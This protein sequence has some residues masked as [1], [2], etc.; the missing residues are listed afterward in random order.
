MDQSPLPSYPKA[1]AIPQKIQDMS[2]FEVI[3]RVRPL[4]APES[5]SGRIYST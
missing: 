1:T 4:Q 5:D 2:Q 3:C